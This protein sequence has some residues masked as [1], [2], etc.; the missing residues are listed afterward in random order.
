AATAVA[1]IEYPRHFL[2]A[3]RLVV[4]LRVL[5]VDRMAG[6]CFEAAFALSHCSFLVRGWNRGGESGPSKTRGPSAPFRCK[7]SAALVDQYVEGLLIAVGVRA[8]G[9]GQRL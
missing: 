8:L 5:P 3:S 2:F 1:D 7:P 6:R 9:L 4:E